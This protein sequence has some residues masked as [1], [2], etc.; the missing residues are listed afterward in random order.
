MARCYAAC[1]LTGPGRVGLGVE[2]GGSFHGAAPP[3]PLPEPVDFDL[4]RILRQTRV[5][6][7]IKEYRLV[8]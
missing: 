5:G 1:E 3:K 7:L 6:G 8:A 4:Y 2:R